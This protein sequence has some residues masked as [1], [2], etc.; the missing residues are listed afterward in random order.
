MKSGVIGFVLLAALAVLAGCS[1]FVSTPPQAASSGTP[2]PADKIQDV[3]R[4]FAGPFEYET[5]LP[6]GLKLNVVVYDGA[7]GSR[8]PGDGSVL[9][10]E[11]R[12]SQGRVA[13]AGRVAPDGTLDTGLQ[14]AAA[15]EDMTL[16]LVGA[17]FEPR[18]IL[19]PRMVQ[20]SGVNRTVGMIFDGGAARAAAD[21]TKDSDGDGHCGRLRRLPQQYERRVRLP[22][23]RQRQAD[24]GLRGPVRPGEGGRRGLQRLHR[25]VHG[26]G[27]RRRLERHHEDH[28]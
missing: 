26:P 17:G 21:L 16:T 13:Y 2:L 27:D 7:G 5:V 22:D 20:Y 10:A 14:L 3:S 15:P 12:D 18:S 4:S 24:R 11:L 9:I 1:L 25:Q 8:S 28:R 23:S 6:V 19:I